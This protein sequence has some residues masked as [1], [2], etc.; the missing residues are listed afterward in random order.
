MNP[1]VSVE[2]TGK[3]VAFPIDSKTL[4]EFISTL[5]GQPQNLEKTYEEAFSVDH[6]WFIHFFSL[7]L[8]RIQQQNAPEPLAFEAT[9]Q[10]RDK[11]ER[12]IT[13]WQAF[14]H[15]S[16]T[17]NIVSVGAKFHLALLIQFPGKPTPE[18]QELIFNFDSRD[19]QQSLVEILVGRQPSVGTITIEIR[20]T[21]RTW[22]DDMLRL[23]DAELTTIQATEGKLKKKLRKI[24]LPFFSLSFP[25]M[26]FIFFVYAEWSKRGTKEIF[27][28]K[29]V[30]AI[31]SGKTDLQSL[32]A[33]ADLLLNEAINGG[34]FKYRDASIAIYSLIFAAVIFFVGIF[35]AQPNP[36][37]VVLSP[38]SIKNRTEI[39]ERQKRKSLWLLFSMVGSIALGIVGN[40]IYD[41]IK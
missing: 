27:Q 15:F 8:Q 12:K 36:S 33:K 18:R 23:I 40:F 21:E 31:N 22:A 24:F 26:M 41:A 35:L 19:K 13:S 9:I 38:A 30:A 17:L 29:A 10:Y 16:E 37:F 34:E 4:G 20:H 6:Q 1:M 39:L 25:F 2:V 5:L 28:Q 3:S 32:H 11:I 7:I 14:Q